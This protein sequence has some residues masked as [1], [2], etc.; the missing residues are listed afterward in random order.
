[1]LALYSNEACEKCSHRAEMSIKS[2][3]FQVGMRC[4]SNPEE[5]ALMQKEL[6]D[7]IVE[8]NPKLNAELLRKGTQHKYADKTPSELRDI[9]HD[10]G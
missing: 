1:M 8:I 7:L 4:D 9:Y 3:I 6:T 10:V 5:G 2:L